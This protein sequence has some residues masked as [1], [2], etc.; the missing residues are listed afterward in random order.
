M[1]R[2]I[3]PIGLILLA[4]GIITACTSSVSEI[5]E[6]TVTPPVRTESAISVEPQSQELNL[7]ITSPNINMVTELNQINV[8]GTTSPDATLSVN[9]RH[10]FPDAEGLFSIDINFSDPSIPM[11]IEIIAS[12]ITGET[13]SEIRP[14]IFSGEPFR[15]GVF[16]TV[17]SVAPSSVTLNTESGVMSLS[18][19]AKTTISL[20]GLA[21]PSVSDIATGTLV[22]V[23]TQG[24]QAKSILAVP[25]RPVLTRHFTGVITASEEFGSLANARITMMDSSKRMITAI[26]T[27]D[28]AAGAVGTL[29]TAVLEQDISSGDLK[30]T[31]IDTALNSAERILEALTM[32]QKIESDQSEENVTALR[33]RLAEHGVRNVSM[34]LDQQP[35][36]RWENAVET[37]EKTFTKLFSEHQICPL[38]AD[39]T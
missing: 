22:G 34:L 29:V 28:I 1:N 19:D 39:V 25:I 32:N 2:H 3:L 24:A 27:D 9:G 10:I 37:A 5:P 6:P 14:I 8:A 26:T 15:S 35:Y 18:V 23:I 36:E 17:S 13:R 20:H 7:R 21:S 33:R 31:A 38:S 30:V 12:S 16:G 4:L 11:I